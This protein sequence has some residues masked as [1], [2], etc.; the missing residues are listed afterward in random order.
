MSLFCI[1][2]YIINMNNTVNLYLHG[3][4]FYW[5]C[6]WWYILEAF[7]NLC[8]N[9]L[10]GY[11]WTINGILLATIITLFSFNFLPRTSVIFRDYFKSDKKEFLLNHFIY[12]MVTVII[13]VITALIIEVIPTGGII[14]FV[15]KSIVVAFIS[16][17]LFII[18]YKKNQYFVGLAS[19]LKNKFKF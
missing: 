1:Y 16:A 10:L 17:F 8:L 4:G 11:I 3:N 9:I 14:K 12:F 13:A 19:I 18:A 15:I 2:F 7:M 6:R 5:Q